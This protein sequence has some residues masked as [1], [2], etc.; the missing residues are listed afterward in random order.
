MIFLD[1]ACPNRQADNGH[2]DLETMGRC[3]CWLGITIALQLAALFAL[4]NFVIG[5]SSHSQPPAV[6]ITMMPPGLWGF[7]VFARYRTCAERILAYVTVILS[8]CWLLLAWESNVRF[9]F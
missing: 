5:T 2:A 7:Y 9:W 4:P 1:D 3:T 6:L 8:T